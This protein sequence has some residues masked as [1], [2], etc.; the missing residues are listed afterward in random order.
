MM[1]RLY[2]KQQ[3]KITIIKI[4][5]SFFVGIL[6]KVL[7]CQDDLGS[8]EKR[9]VIGKAPGFPQVGEDFTANDVFEEH[10]QI[11]LVLE[12]AEPER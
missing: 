7:D 4:K 5:D 2:L 3:D 12:R 8:V 6:V 11:Q 9:C 10:V 1:S